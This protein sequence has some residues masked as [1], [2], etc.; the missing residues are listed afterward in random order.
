M[1]SNSL[2]DILSGKTDMSFLH[3]E[4]KF[5]KL[6]ERARMERVKRVKGEEECAY[7]CESFDLPFPSDNFTCSPANSSRETFSRTA[8]G[9]L[10]FKRGKTMYNQ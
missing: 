8:W 9:I 10:F 7:T 6:R 5:D 3:F 4:G 2:Q 1:L